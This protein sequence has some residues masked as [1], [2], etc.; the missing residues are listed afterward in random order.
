MSQVDAGRIAF[1]GM[2]AMGKKVLTSLK[3]KL[4]YHEFAYLVA[5]D[6]VVTLEDEVL[7]QGFGSAK[8]LI[9][10]QPDLVVE[11][12]GHGAVETVVPQLLEQGIDVVIA[13]IG[14]L[15][16]DALYAKLKRTA[17]RGNARITLI[18]GAIGGLDALRCALLSELTSIVYEGRKPPHAWRG[19][20][21]ERLCD[22]DQL[23]GAK[24]FFEGTA[25]EAAREYPKNANVTAAVAL[26]GLG[27]DHTSVKLIADPAVSQNSHT[28]HVS[29]A[30]GE[31]S[32][33]LKNNPLPDNKRTS[34]LAAL[35][36]EEAVLK[37]IDTITF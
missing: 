13:S 20:P 35:S 32:I 11:C 8:D 7:A 29:G 37:S 22:L 30:F 16:D 34:W 12:A 31:F 6:R 19:T 18:S 33:V 27:F 23:T 24:V 15:V 28:L 2:G 14:A 9:D 26:S 36:V 3:H 4:P 21:A 25:R 5:E 10:W 17:M 1:I